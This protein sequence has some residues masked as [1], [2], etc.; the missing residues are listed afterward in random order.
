MQAAPGLPARRHPLPVRAD[1]GEGRLQPPAPARAGRSA[2]CLPSSVPPPFPPR[3]HPRLGGAGHP[4]TA[5]PPSACLVLLLAIGPAL[6]AAPSA[7]LPYK[8]G[9][10]G[11][12]PLVPVQR[13]SP[14]PAR[15]ARTRG[16]GLARCGPGTSSHLPSLAASLAWHRGKTRGDGGQAGCRQS[17]GTTAPE[18]LQGWW[19]WRRAAESQGHSSVPLCSHGSVPEQGRAQHTP[20]NPAGQHH[21]QPRAHGAMTTVPACRAV[22][23]HASI[24]CKSRDIVKTLFSA[25]PDL[26]KPQVQAEQR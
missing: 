11:P 4:H 7:W 14:G 10:Q 24:N 23:G 25:G 3:S 15:D 18:E 20:V 9:Q 22:A 19:P 2:A 13:S 12:A 5:V 26:C 8:G 1:A 17:P 16:H 6:P 21:R